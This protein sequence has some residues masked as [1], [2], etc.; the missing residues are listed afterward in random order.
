M[1]EFY[2]KEGDHVLLVDG[3]AIA[4][5]KLY[6]VD[7]CRLPDVLHVGGGLYDAIIFTKMPPEGVL[8]RAI[9]KVYWGGYIIALGVEKIVKEAGYQVVNGNPGP[10]VLRRPPL[11]EA[12]TEAY[13]LRLPSGG[14]DWNPET[15]TMHP[16]YLEKFKAIDA[17]WK[18]AT[19]IEY[20]CGRGEMTRLIALSGAK[21]VYAMDSASAAVSLTGKFCSDLGNVALVCDDALRWNAPQKADIVVALDFV[22]HVEEKDLPKLFLQMLGNMKLGG[23]IHIVTPLGPDAVRDHKWAPSPSK[24]REKMEGV[25]FKYKR[26]VRP[27]GSR[28]FFAEF[29]K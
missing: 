15:K 4:S 16:R 9:E 1:L 7:N 18:G 2:L 12:W 5:K 6:R 24:L 3:A 21:M 11:P 27:K 10:L 13:Y 25:G 14:E 8:R 19:V 17:E 29:V 26:H 28:K 20:G 23:L 22:E